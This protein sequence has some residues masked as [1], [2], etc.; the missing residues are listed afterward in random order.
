VTA[1]GVEVRSAARRT[2]PAGLSF[3]GAAGTV[4]GSRFLLEHQDRRYLVDCGLFQGEAAWRRQNWN[5]FSVD[6]RTID[7]VVLT[8]AHLDHSGYLPVLVRGGFRGPVLCSARTAEVAAI[9]LRD[10]AHLQEEDARHARHAGYSRHDPPLPL[11][12]A[13]DAERSIDL[14][15]PAAGDRA[16]LPGGAQVEFH[17]A[18]HILGSRFVVVELAGHRV[19][20]SGDLG[21]RQHPLLRPPEQPAD[22]DVIVVESTYGNRRHVPADD[23]RLGRLIT[24]TVNRGGVTLMPAFAVDRT[25]VL[26]HTLARLRRRGLIPALPVYVDSPMALAALDVYR[27]AVRAADPEIRPELTTVAD[28]FDPGDLRLVHTAEES[29]RINDPHRPCIII[30]ASGMATGGRVLHHLRHQL[31]NARNSVVLTGYQVVGT[32]GRQLLD[33]ATAVKIHGH[34]VA[35]HAQISAVPELSAHADADELIDWLGSAKAAPE[36]TYV[37]HGEPDA[38]AALVGRIGAG[39]GRLAVAPH[40]LERVRL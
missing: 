20:F 21:R 4:T 40:H 1:S 30:S 31:P 16:D 29:E 2:E 35:V 11:F 6:P 7:G 34:Y 28:P 18:G 27:N 22:A 17:R 5:P 13:A 10:A 39:L 33:G 23:E 14:L 25:P 12:D 9:V 8:H 37:V 3:L 26:L 24:A 15:C 32:R 19:L 36:T 38:A